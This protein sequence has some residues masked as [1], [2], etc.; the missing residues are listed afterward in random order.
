MPARVARARRSFPAGAPRGGAPGGV[1]AGGAVDGSADP[2][3]DVLR[4]IAWNT[5]LARTG[6][7]ASARAAPSRRAAV[8]P[9]LCSTRSRPLAR[10]ALSAATPLCTRRRSAIVATNVES[11]TA[12][13]VARCASGAKATRTRGRGQARRTSEAHELVGREWLTSGTQACQID[14]VRL[15]AWPASR[16]T[17]VARYRQSVHPLYDDQCRPADREDGRGAERG[18]RPRAAQRESRRL[19]HA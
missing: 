13:L 14:E 17:R 19:R 1:T 7:A 4:A 5:L 9:R 11:L 2:D 18:A 6:S 10:A 3:S 15:P 12:E 16:G 8:R